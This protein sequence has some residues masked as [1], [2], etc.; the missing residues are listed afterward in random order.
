MAHPDRVWTPQELV[1]ISFKHPAYFAP[2]KDFH[3]SNTNTIL[4]GMIIE[5]ITGHTV[6]S[7]FQHRIFAPLGMKN[8][9]M[10]PRTSSALPAPYSQGYMLNTPVEQGVANK[11]TVQDLL[12]VTRWNPSWG[13]TAGAAISTL[14][15][16]QIWA[17]ALAMGKL[18]KPATQKER[19]TWYTQLPGPRGYGLAIADFTGFVGHNGQLPGYQS[20]E[21]YMQ[22]KDETI[23]V[24]TNLYAAPD[25]SEPAD[26]L[27]NIIMKDLS[28]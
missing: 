17:K 15:D 28:S 25:G 27:A 2:G 9:I 14:H 20:F 13:W 18:L 24:L 6:E 12:N 26:A 7:E 8:S 1:A 19:L 22:A 11:G 16:L 4:L 3:Y 10:P 21:G 5:H 23:I